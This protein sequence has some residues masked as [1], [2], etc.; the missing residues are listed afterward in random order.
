[1]K[2]KAKLRA[3]QTENE[4]I[5]LLYYH[6]NQITINITQNFPK[7]QK[8]TS[9]WFISFSQTLSVQSSTPLPP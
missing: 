1:M 3:A 4:L 2:L 7:S 8:L 6:I 5:P 9:C